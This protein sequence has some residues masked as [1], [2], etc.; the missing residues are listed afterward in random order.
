MAVEAP[1]QGHDSDRG[2]DQHSFSRRS[3]WDPE[4]HYSI[5]HSDSPVTVDGYAKGEPKRLVCDGCGTS[6]LLTEEPSPGVD[7]LGHAPGWPNRGA[8]SDWWAEQFQR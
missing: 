8:K 3:P 5:E 6:V 1:A 2:Q 7:E 4:T